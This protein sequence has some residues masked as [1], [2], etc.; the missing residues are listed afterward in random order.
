MQRIAESTRFPFIYIFQVSFSPSTPLSFRANKCAP[1]AI[2]SRL[3]RDYYHGLSELYGEEEN[4]RR[5]LTTMLH[6]CSSSVA[7]DHGAGQTCC[8]DLG[9]TRGWYSTTT[10]RQVCNAMECLTL[11]YHRG[12]SA[13]VHRI[14][15]CVWFTCLRKCWRWCS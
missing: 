1:R 14:F 8:R 10:H 12:V 9:P 7:T 2:T 15:N 4:R 5:G 6:D 13:V 11:S 3:L